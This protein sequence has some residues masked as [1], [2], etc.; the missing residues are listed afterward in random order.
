MTQRRGNV[1]TIF[2]FSLLPL[3]GF[4]ALAV[5]IGFQRL[6]HSQASAVATLAAT[7]AVNA[8]VALRLC[9]WM[10]HPTKARSPNSLVSPQLMSQSRCRMTSPPTHKDGER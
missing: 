9:A 6:M 3:T 2:A 10:L 4:G 8:A 1:A 5:D 7:A